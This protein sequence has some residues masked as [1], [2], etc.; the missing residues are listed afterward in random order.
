MESLFIDSTPLGEKVERAYKLA[1]ECVFPGFLFTSVNVS[2]EKEISIEIGNAEHACSI[3]LLPW[4]GTAFSYPVA[5]FRDVTDPEFAPFIK[6]TLF[7]HEMSGF[8]W[9][10]AFM[11]CNC[12]FEA[13]TFAEAIDYVSRYC[14]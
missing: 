9:Q 13:D 8:F 10:S 5:V 14:E 4:D 1:E 7:R 6:G 2:Y 11:G 12:E 3:L